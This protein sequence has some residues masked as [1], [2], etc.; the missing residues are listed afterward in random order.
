M[1]VDYPALIPISDILKPV[2]M[3]D[4]AANSLANFFNGV[5]VENLNN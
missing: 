4:A 2:D 1:V 5:V 3:I